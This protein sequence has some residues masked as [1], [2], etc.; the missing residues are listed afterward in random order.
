[1]KKLYSKLLHYWFVH[2]TM[3]FYR[4]ITRSRTHSSLKELETMDYGLQSSISNFL[5][6][7]RSA[8]FYSNFEIKENY[9]SL[10]CSGILQSKENK[11]NSVYISSDLG[12]ETTKTLPMSTHRVCWNSRSH[13][14]MEWSSG[15]S[16][17]F[18]STGSSDVKRKTEKLFK[19]KS[20]E[21]TEELKYNVRY[22]DL[23]DEKVSFS[24]DSH[25]RK[26]SKRKE[27][28][29]ISTTLSDSSGR[30]K[31]LVLPINCST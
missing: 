21:N 10:G 13:D 8:M 4:K 15:E 28:I 14:K 3:S 30:G 26:V 5:K 11:N 16:L 9:C 19:G 18:I 23:D 29:S 12:H 1:L 24:S 25:P 17:D 6:P 31:S 22:N 20:D 7:A 2:K 27:D